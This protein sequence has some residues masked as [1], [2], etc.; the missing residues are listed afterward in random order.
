MASAHRGIPSRLFVSGTR[1][2]LLLL[3][4]PRMWRRAACS[5]RRSRRVVY[6]RRASSPATVAE[7]A[8]QNPRSTTIFA[9]PSHASQRNDMARRPGNP[10][11]DMA[12][13][14]RTAGL[15][16]SAPITGNV[17][18]SGREGVVRGGQI[19]GDRGSKAIGAGG[20]PSKRRPPFPRLAIE[21]PRVV[22][23]PL[24]MFP[25]SVQANRASCPGRTSSQTLSMVT[26]APP[27]ARSPSMRTRQCFCMT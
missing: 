20:R 15:T 27:M 11:S 13:N 1:P 26:S 10:D 7:Q 9:R 3:M 17:G 8:G 23:P 18:E 19:E 16:P 5:M 6:M 2:R 25:A 4:I 14:G 12:R 24:S 21:A 22:H